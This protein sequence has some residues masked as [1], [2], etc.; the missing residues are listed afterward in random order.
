MKQVL[1][2]LYYKGEF[3]GYLTCPWEGGQLEFGYD[4][5]QED[6]QHPTRKFDTVDAFFDHLEECYPGYR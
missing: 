6:P 3:V 1:T 5:N 4:A 2:T